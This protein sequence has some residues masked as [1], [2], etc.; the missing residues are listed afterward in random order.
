MRKVVTSDQLPKPAGPYSPAV[1]AGDFVYVSGQGPTDPAT[2]EMVLDSVQAETR[3]VLKNVQAILEA[4]GTSLENVVK[5]NVYL[6]DRHDFAAMNE[7]YKEFF[8]HDPPARTTV[9]AHPPVEIR[10]EIDCVAYLPR[11]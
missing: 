3:Q 5:C 10:V 2:G 1:I 11:G 7:V 4:A 9:Q 8:P 6:A